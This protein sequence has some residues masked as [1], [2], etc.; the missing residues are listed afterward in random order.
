MYAPWPRTA[1]GLDVRDDSN[2]R[3]TLTSD[4]SS[5]DADDARNGPAGG[6][7]TSFFFD[8]HILSHAGL[9]IALNVNIVDSVCVS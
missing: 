6:G 5:C 3:I 1:R 9:K 8:F 4:M 7:T 2:R